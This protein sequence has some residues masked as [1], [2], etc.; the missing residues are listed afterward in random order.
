MSLPVQL[1][2]GYVSIYGGQSIQ[3]LQLPYNSP[4]QFGTINQMGSSLPL[5]YDVGK[6]VMYN[7]NDTEQV[8]YEGITY[9]I[10]PEN[11]I[12]LTENDLM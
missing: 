9:Y 3:G 10:L 2:P 1:S 11:K 12:I 7:G 4:Y 8:I 6:S 5:G